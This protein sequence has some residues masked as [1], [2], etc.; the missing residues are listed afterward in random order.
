MV[1]FLGKDEQISFICFIYN[2]K[3][4]ISN[5]HVFIY[6]GLIYFLGYQLSWIAARKLAYSWILFSCFC[7]GLHSS[8]KKN[9][10]SLN[11]KLRGSP[12]PTK[13]LIIGPQENKWID[14][15]STCNFSLKCSTLFWRSCTNGGISPF[16]TNTFFSNL[17]SLQRK[18]ILFIII[19]ATHLFLLWHVKLITFRVLPILVYKCYRKTFHLTLP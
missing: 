13:S 15:Y 5:I 11:I 10:H 3:T 18:K 6:C 7:R 4:T 14:S 16:S 17:P 8:L 2:G 19:R 9:C 12:I 1:D